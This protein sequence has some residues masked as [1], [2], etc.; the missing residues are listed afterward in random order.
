MLEHGKSNKNIKE[1][2]QPYGQIKIMPT[3][4]LCLVLDPLN[5]SSQSLTSVIPMSISFDVSSLMEMQGW[6]AKKLANA[7]FLLLFSEECIG[8]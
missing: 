5:Q 8:D 6:S 2:W 3:L 1:I 4:A 7:N